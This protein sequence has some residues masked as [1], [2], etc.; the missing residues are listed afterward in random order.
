MATQKYFTFIQ[1]LRKMQKKI[2]FVWIW[3]I[4]TS[5]LAR[6]YKS[7]WYDVFGSDKYSSEIIDQ[8]QKEW[9]H[10]VI[11]EDISRIDETFEKLVYSSAVGETQTELQRARYL[12]IP[13]LTYPQALWEVVNK[14]KLISIAWTHGKSTTTS[15]ISLILKASDK[16]FAS[17]VW[18]TLKEF[19]NSN[20]YYRKDTSENNIFFVLESCEYKRNFLN[21]K[22]FIWVITNIEVDHLDYYKDEEDYTTAFQEFVENIIPWWFVILS[23]EDKNSAK[24]IWIRRDISY[25]IA[26]KEYYKIGNENI[27]FP[28]IVLQ[29]P[30]N[31]ILF[32]AQL[33]YITGKIIGI[34]ELIILSALQNYNGIW[35]RMEKIGRT[36]NGNI[37]MSDYGHHPTEIIAT[38]KALK[39]KFVDKKLF[40]IFQPHQYSR[41]RELLEGF[42]NCFT[43]CDTLVVPNIYESRDTEE[44]KKRMN[45]EVFIDAINHPNKL[46]WN[47]FENTIQITENYD[48]KNPNSSIILLLWA[49]D[50]DDIR[51]KIKTLHFA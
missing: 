4:G 23:G 14:T 19:G 20:F 32:D 43:Y 29:V 33:A 18:S 1:F 42:K 47:G 12:H 9:I 2:Y 17:I 8:L 27:S 22:P 50:I 51:Y 16:S 36:E 13:T 21:Y 3:W 41:T 5:W 30:G 38:T 44:D 39:E 24:L 48:F 28:E 45:E 37:L 46:F 10:C 34:E 31:H 15:L 49:G 35:R 26:Y 7:I 25:I 40:V 6:Y 11:W